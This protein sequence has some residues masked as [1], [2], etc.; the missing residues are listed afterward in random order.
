MQAKLSKLSEIVNKFNDLRT[1]ILPDSSM[2][3]EAD[4]DDESDDVEDEPAIEAMP[5]VREA[6]MT[7]SNQNLMALTLPSPKAATSGLKTPVQSLKE[8]MTAYSNSDSEDQLTKDQLEEHKLYDLI[9]ASWCLL[10]A[11][12][13]N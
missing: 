13:V 11:V 7:P 2:A 8:L 9:L 5:L 4:G 12:V 1:E 6:W 10:R 3:S